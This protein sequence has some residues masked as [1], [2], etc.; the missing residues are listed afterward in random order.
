MRNKCAEAYREVL[1]T[2]RLNSD[3]Y[4]IADFHDLESNDIFD[5][6]IPAF[7]YIYDYKEKG[8]YTHQRPLLSACKNRVIVKDPWTGQI[9]EMIMMASNNYLGLTTHPKVVQAGIDAYYKY[10]S[11]SGSA[12]LLSGTFDITRELELK[13]AEIKRCEDAVVFSTGYAANVGTASALLR[14]GDVAIIDKLDH[15]SIIDGCKLSGAEIMVAKHQDMNHLEKCLKRC[16]S[17]YN[18]KL[19]IVDGIYGMFGD[20]CPLPE[21]KELAGKYEA[22]IL[23]DDAH[24]MGVIGK[25]GRGT[26]EYYGMEGDIDL[27]LG[28]LSKSL[29]GVGGFVAASKEVIN[30]LRVYGRS[31][32]FSTALPASVCASVK[33]ALEVIEE[34]PGLIQQL[35]KNVKYLY[36]NLASNGFDVSPPGTGMLSVLIGDELLMRK[37]SKRIHEMG[38]YINPVPFPSVPKKGARLKFSLMATHTQEDLD[39]A[40]EIFTNAC[41]EFGLLENYAISGSTNK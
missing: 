28:T 16:T 19:I 17:K 34:E 21:I 7:R 14:P 22:K 29:A 20:I 24:A 23:V 33:A 10:G 9:R 5:K 25:Y 1:S 37:I 3:N 8:Y 13:L 12:P 30:Y 40:I 6:A 11:G 32:F 26:S 31:Y 39:S 35:H 36:D 2:G 15:A 27:V 41:S 38:L 4:T 18:G